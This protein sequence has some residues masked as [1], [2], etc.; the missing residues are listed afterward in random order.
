MVGLCKTRRIGVLAA[1]G[2]SVGAG[3]ALLWPLLPE[4]IKRVPTIELVALLG[5]LVLPA[6]TALALVFERHS[7]RSGGRAATVAEEAP[8][9]R[10][11]DPAWAPVWGAIASHEAEPRHGGG[12]VAAVRR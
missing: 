11:S 3:L 2:A 6:G 7:R 1:C 5:L 4:A 9:Q 8:Q 12:L 10:P